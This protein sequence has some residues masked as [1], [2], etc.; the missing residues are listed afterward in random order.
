MIETGW[1]LPPPAGKLFT[2][3][4]PVARNPD[5][6]AITGP[7]TEEFVID[8]G[9]TPATEKLNYPAASAPCR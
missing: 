4:V 7:A 6:S 2:I 9:Q 5:G 8:K 3:T 1:G